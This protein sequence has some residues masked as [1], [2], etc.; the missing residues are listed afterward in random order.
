MIECCLSA[1]SGAVLTSTVL[2]APSRSTVER[3][4][5]ARGCFVICRRSAGS[6]GVGR[7]STAAI[8]SFARSLSAEGPFGFTAAITVPGDLTGTL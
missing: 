3:D 6:D 5:L 8:V 4:L 7:P 1:G 2:V